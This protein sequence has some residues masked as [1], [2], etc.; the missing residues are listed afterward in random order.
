VV[1]NKPMLFD[2]FVAFSALEV[3]T[4]HFA[5]KFLESDLR[6][7]AEFF[8]GLACVPKKS[9]HFC[10]SEIAWV[11]A[12]NSVRLEASASITYHSDFIDALAL[13]GYMHAKLSGCC[14][15]E[16]TYTILNTC[17]NY[18]IFGLIL[19]QHQPLHLHIIAGVTPVA[20]GTQIS[21]IKAILQAEL[22]A[23]ERASNFTGYESFTA[24]GTLMV[25]KD[26]ITG[27]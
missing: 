7:P 12:N 24:N 25:E 6:R 23:R 19:L 11:N 4:H 3:F 9:L 20:P 5:H 17:G 26:T 1:G 21:K 10:R 14:I 22:Y 27:V 16:I 15:D 8:P 13:P 18:E 2:E